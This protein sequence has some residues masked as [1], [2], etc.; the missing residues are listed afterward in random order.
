VHEL[1]KILSGGSYTKRMMDAYARIREIYS[2]QNASER[3]A[4]MAE[5]MA[6]WKK[7]IS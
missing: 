7:K 1:G 3:V 6:G 4:D 2:S 5:E